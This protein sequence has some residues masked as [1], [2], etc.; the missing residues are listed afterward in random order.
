[1]AT[2]TSVKGISVEFDT[3]TNTFF[4]VA[5]E[6]AL[7][8][9][10]SKPIGKSLLDALGATKAPN[11]ANHN[12]LIVPVHDGGKDA[13]GNTMFFDKRFTRGQIGQPSP[14]T[15][16]KEATTKW[17]GLKMGGGVGS[18]AQADDWTGAENGTGS[19][20]KLVLNTSQ[21]VLEGGV[22][23]P[24]FILIA[25]EL[26]HC[27]HNLLGTNKGGTK[28]TVGN[29]LIKHEEVYCVGLGDYT[30]EPICENSIRSEWKGIP[31][32]ATYG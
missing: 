30:N 22:M 18:G 15:I 3:G 16:K 2:P 5:V 27:L 6:D 12:V 9:I 31:Q 20:S 29:E 26:V 21:Y 28:I 32:R 25:H 11:N 19:S 23:I 14:E 7:K 1:M 10:G 24:G 17:Q 8:K 13:Y 4:G